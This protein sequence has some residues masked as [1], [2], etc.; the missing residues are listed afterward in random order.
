MKQA[1][2]PFPKPLRSGQIWKMRDSNLQVELV[3]KML[4]HY[5]LVRPEIKRTP[6]SISGIKVVE[7]F[8]A[9]NKAV[10]VHE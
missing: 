1:R 9:D 4:V 3:G 6:T 5:K 10:L 2:R 8:L 7:K